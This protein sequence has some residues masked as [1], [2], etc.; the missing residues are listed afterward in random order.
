MARQG[1]RV[2]LH[3]LWTTIKDIFFMSV[4]SAPLQNRRVPLSFLQAS[5]GVGKSRLFYELMLKQNEDVP[6]K[7]HDFA[8]KVVFFL[9]DFNG[10]TPATRD[11]SA[12]SPKYP[13]LPVSTRLLYTQRCK[14]SVPWVTFVT[15][16]MCE[17][18]LDLTYL[19]PEAVLE[20]LRKSL[21]AG[22]NI[23]FLI[24]ELS[25]T[26][27]IGLSVP[28]SIR[29]EIC[30]LQDSEG[31]VA[32]FSA[33][34][35]ESL[36]RLVQ[37]GS[38][39]AIKQITDLPL[40]SKQDAVN[41]LTVAVENLNF[42]LQGHETDPR[43]N[44]KIACTLARLSGGHARTI[45][46]FVN[47]LSQHAHQPLILNY[48]INTSAESLVEMYGRPPPA[49]M[50]ACI[51]AAE[52]GTSERV[53]EEVKYVDCVAR[54]HLIASI[55]ENATSFVPQVPP[56]F[57]HQWQKVN[58]Q[59]S[60]A[61]FTHLGT[62]LGC[63]TYWE[64]IA[65]E[66]V[67]S[68]WEVLI[69]HCRSLQLY[70][71]VTLSGLYKTPPT[72]R[73]NELLLIQVNGSLLLDGIKNFDP[74][75][76]QVAS[77]TTDIRCRYV[78]RPIDPQNPGFDLLLFFRTEF[79]EEG[80]LPLFVE[81]KFSRQQATTTLGLPEVLKKYESCKGFA[82][83][84]LRTKQFAVMFLCLRGIT[85]SAIEN[86]PAQCMFLD[87]ACVDDLYGPTVSALIQTVQDGLDHA[88][89]TTV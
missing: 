20:L 74:D 47:I 3:K 19:T 54:G 52:V 29:N 57:V 9:I 70:S 10:R 21:P 38:S 84:H 73:E 88:E 49:L 23:V 17:K 51:L 39:R 65:L 33:L 48:C 4:E 64:P 8:S 15:A 56:I 37:T 34:E 1:R 53:F 78:W 76:S 60:D 58:I 5:P 14:Q 77:S 18:T 40:L 6:E 11:Q 32:I 22:A 13:Y 35:S 16:F 69:R 75:G 36:I 83:K 63:L 41:I 82:S 59:T 68:S 27:E 45:E 26:S 2:E 85:N 25:K 31:V 28:T 24:D 80:C 71:A 66:S 61:F 46:L 79:L 86:A 72:S 87:Q 30:A 7:L 67:H 42:S 12:Y 62:L 89:R 81:C 50:R 55:L 44:G 43:L